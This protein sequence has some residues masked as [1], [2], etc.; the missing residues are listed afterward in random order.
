MT[1]NITRTTAG[2]KKGGAEDKAPFGKKIEPLI[3]R[4]TAEDFQR[5]LHNEYDMGCASEGSSNGTGR[6]CG[7]VDFDHHLF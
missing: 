3:D 7:F 1:S 2:S 4:M 6:S 5:A